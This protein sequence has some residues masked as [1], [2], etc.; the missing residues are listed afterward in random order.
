MG[1]MLVIDKKEKIKSHHSILYEDVFR[2]GMLKLSIYNFSCYFVHLLDKQL[3]RPTSNP[4]RALE[5]CATSK[6]TGLWTARS[7]TN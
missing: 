7:A 4:A 1:S 5:W 3:L 2:Y 6:C